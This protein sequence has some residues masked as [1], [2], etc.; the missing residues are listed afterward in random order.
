MIRARNART[1]SILSA[2]ENAPEGYINVYFR[3][4][5]LDRESAPAL[6]EEIKKVGTLLY[7]VD[8]RDNQRMVYDEA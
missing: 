5:N 3:I 1:A 2:S 7:V 4:Y 8:H 6:V